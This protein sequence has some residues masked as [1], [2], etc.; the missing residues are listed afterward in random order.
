[1]ISNTLAIK[2]VKKHQATKRASGSTPLIRGNMTMARKPCNQIQIQI[3][4]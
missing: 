4:Q 2:I 1:M 3:F